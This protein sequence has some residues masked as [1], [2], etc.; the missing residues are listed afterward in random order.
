MY[1]FFKMLKKPRNKQEAK[2][3]GK[4]IAFSRKYLFFRNVLEARKQRKRLRRVSVESMNIQFKYFK[5]K[6]LERK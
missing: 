6:E 1:Y 2:E 3:E 5:T 4:E